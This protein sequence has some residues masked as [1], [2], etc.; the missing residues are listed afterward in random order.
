MAQEMNA[1][2][3]VFDTA[4]TGHTLKMLSFPQLIEKG[5]SKLI[6]IKD[7]LNGIISMMG[8]GQENQIGNMFNKLTELKEKT[9]VLKEI[10][11]DSSKT[12][13]IGVCIPEF[14]S[15]YETE[16]LVQELTY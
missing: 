2:V 13:F 5:L 8:M 4:P 15:V 9:N 6:E 12:T 7:K 10:M 11:K 1:E 16:R 3:V 14:L